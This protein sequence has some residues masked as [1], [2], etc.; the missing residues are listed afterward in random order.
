MDYLCKVI[1]GNYIVLVVFFK[2]FL[3]NQQ[4]IVFQ[5]KTTE[6]NSLSITDIVLPLQGAVTLFHCR[7][8]TTLSSWY[9]Q[10]S[11]P[12][13]PSLRSKHKREGE[14]GGGGVRGVRE[15]WKRGT[16]EERRERSACNKSPHNSMFLRSKSGRK[17]LIGRDMSRKVWQLD[18]QV[19]VLK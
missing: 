19:R 3:R 8:P 4:G 15:K 13:Q 9:V 6:L 12:G 14:G 1:L 7:G 11:F 17:M 16:G 2:C 5:G 18:S 10:T